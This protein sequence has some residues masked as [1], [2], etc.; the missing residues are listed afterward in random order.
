[1]KARS[2]G[3]TWRLPGW[4]RKTPGVVTA[5]GVSSACNRPSAIGASAS[6][7]GSCASPTPRIAAHQPYI[8]GVQETPQVLQW[9]ED[10]LSEMCLSYVY[11]TL[12]PPK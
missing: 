10:T 8:N 9:G 3:R 2:L 5:K 1:M 12:K 11:A 7:P 6:G 4:Y